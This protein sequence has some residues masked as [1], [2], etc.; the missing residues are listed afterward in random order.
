GHVYGTTAHAA[1]DRARAQVA[2]LLGASADEIIFTSGGSEANNR[3]PLGTL[4]RRQNTAAGHVV[5]SAIEHPAIAESCKLLGR[6]GCKVTVVPVDRHGLV[7]PEAVR[8]AITRSTTMV[9]IM[10]SNNE[11]GTLQ[12][13]RDIAAI[14]H[15]HGALMHTDAAQSVGKV[16]LDVN[17]LGVD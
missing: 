11:V 8:R 16:A 12:P 13:I 6:L 9:S 17:D 14:A 3:A 4:F 10:H 15:E 1:V 7:D 2:A 5:T